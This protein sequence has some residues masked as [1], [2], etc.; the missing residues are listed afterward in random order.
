MSEQ[1]AEFDNLRQVAD[2]LVAEGWKVSP[3][4]VYKHGKEG[5]VRPLAD[6]RYPRNA[7][8]KY[9]SVHL[10]RKE[11][12]Q[13][14]VST[15]LQDQKV[16]AEV[17]RLQEQAKHARIK[18]LA[19]EGKYLPREQVEMELAAKVATLAA[20]LAYFAQA[21]A[22]EI[23]ELVGGDTSRIGDLVRYMTAAIDELLNE[24][25]TTRG[26]DVLFVGNES[27]EEV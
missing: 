13:K 9:A 24:Y 10:V 16:Q 27:E 25:A 20:G 23:V 26:F 6:G 2:Y 12:G 8:E 5:R 19:L 15:E 21:R 17:E 4:T 11:I 22:G 18:R 3:S 7:V 1:P 14:A